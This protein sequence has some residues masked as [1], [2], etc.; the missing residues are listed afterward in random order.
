MDYNLN[1]EYNICMYQHIWDFLWLQKTESGY[2]IS[3]SF[4]FDQGRFSMNWVYKVKCTINNLVDMYKRLFEDWVKNNYKR[5]F[6]PEGHRSY[7]VTMPSFMF[8]EAYNEDI[9]LKSLA[10][11]F[12]K[13]I[14]SLFE[15]LEMKRQEDPYVWYEI[16]EDTDFDDEDEDMHKLIVTFYKLEAPKL[17]HKAHL[18]KFLTPLLVYHRNNT[19]GWDF[20]SGDIV[21]ELVNNDEWFSKPYNSFL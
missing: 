21:L 12:L 20:A 16:N 19:E 18:H 6:S 8:L 1:K 10:D 2:D 11:S 4:D 9:F 3:L 17:F 15:E 5:V 7:E 13:E 14:I